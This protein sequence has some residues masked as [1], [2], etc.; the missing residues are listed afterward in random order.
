VEF[1]GLRDNTD[2]T[3]TCFG[4]YGSLAWEKW[5]VDA[6]AG[7]VGLKYDTERFVDLLSERLTGSFDGT[8]VT[9]YVE[10]GYNWDLAP[11]TH[12][13]PLASL[14]YTYLN[15]DSYTESGGASALAFSDQTYNSIKGSLGARLNQTLVESARDFRADLQL[16][17]RWVHEFGDDQS[18]V[19]ATFVNSPAAVFT[20][21]DEAI[22]RDSAVLGAGLHTD[23]NR[24][25]RVYLD[26]D[27]RLSSDESVNVFSA[28]LQYR[29]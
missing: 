24:Q 25:M 23:L 8:E 12:L 27:I 9:A 1:S 21:E 5:Y 13:Q 17:G 20:V 29:W 2:I 18:T 6:V 28:A 11:N 3:A 14:Q 19:D 26:Y 7:Y 22:S 15:L 4:A 16:R 10:A